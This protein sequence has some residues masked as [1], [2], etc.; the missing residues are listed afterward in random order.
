MGN[1]L[2]VIGSCALVAAYYISTRTGKRSSREI[3]TVFAGLAVFALFV[4]EGNLADL[5]VL[6]SHHNVEPIGF[7]IFVCCL[8]FVTAQRTLAKEE[9]L[10]AINQELQ[11][12]N[13]IQSSILPREVPQLAGL[14][15]VARY[16]PM[17]AVAGDLWST[18]G[19]SA[20]SSLT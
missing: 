12:A 1:N 17:S 9:R 14:E 15:I 3:T 5:S 11:I 4:V 19:T 16:V 18:R 20:S 7:F 6:P 8:G 2:F 10:L 13:Q